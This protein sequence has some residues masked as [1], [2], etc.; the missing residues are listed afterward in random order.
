MDSFKT[1][2]LII[3]LWKY[4]QIYLFTIICLLFFTII[5]IFF[6]KS[7]WVL[8]SVEKRRFV[9]WV[10]LGFFFFLMR[11]ENTSQGNISV[12][13]NYFEI[14]LITSEWRQNTS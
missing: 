14:F 13:I 11:P 6:N 1:C 3:I 12:P 9:M 5:I 10:A 4:F 7:S 2:F 8:R